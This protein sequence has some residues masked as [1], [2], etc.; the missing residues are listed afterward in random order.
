MRPASGEAMLRNSIGSVSV[1]K[2]N[3]SFARESVDVIDMPV[4]VQCDFVGSSALHECDNLSREN[5]SP[6]TFLVRVSSAFGEWDSCRVCRFFRISEIFGQIG[7]E[8]HFFK[9]HE[10]L[11]LE[12]GSRPIIFQ[13]ENNSIV[14]S[15]T[16][17]DGFD[18]GSVIASRAIDNNIFVF[19]GDI[20]PK[21]ASF[22][23]FGRDP[24]LPSENSASGSGN[25]NSNEQ[26]KFGYFEFFAIALG[27]VTGIAGIWICVFVAS[28][29]GFNFAIL[30]G[31][32]LFFGWLIAVFHDEILRLAFKAVA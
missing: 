20:S 30:G 16:I 31:I 1:A 27:M 5:I 13:F 26:N 29:R 25:K 12:G 14:V 9:P 2:S 18:F 23:I 8:G 22:I 19:D 21:A 11:H 24:L 15:K 32:I 6:M 10:S 7:I 4:I 3:S 28:K 17:L